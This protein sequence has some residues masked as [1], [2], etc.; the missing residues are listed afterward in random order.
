MSSRPHPGS[1]RPLHGPLQSF[2]LEAEASRLR[3]EEAWRE[4]KRNSI[5][6]RKGEGMNVVLLVMKAGDRLEEHSAPG[7]FSLSVRQG[8]IRFATTEETTEAAA[9]TLLT[10][11]A[12]VRHTVEAL[13]EAV[14]LLTV[15][16]AGGSPGA[17]SSE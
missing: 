7:P 16:G 17:E 4:G 15:A 3:R 10:C 1:E 14:C 8:R 5:T 2:D 11:D 13:E 6:L 12:E 9:G